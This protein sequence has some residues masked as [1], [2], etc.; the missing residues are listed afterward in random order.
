VPRAPRHTHTHK[1]NAGQDRR[2]RE[3]VT[4]LR[5]ACVM[6]EKR[7]CRASPVALAAA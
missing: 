1:A 7:P 5:T 6:S 2:A 3:R 4:D